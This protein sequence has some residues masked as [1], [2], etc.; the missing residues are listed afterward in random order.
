MILSN[1]K[2]PNHKCRPLRRT[3]CVTLNM[4]LRLNSLMF[5]NLFISKDWIDIVLIDD[6]FLSQETKLLI[7]N[8]SRS[9]LSEY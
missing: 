9:D 4:L 2:N 5:W 3:Q 1:K 7:I 6:F 8:D